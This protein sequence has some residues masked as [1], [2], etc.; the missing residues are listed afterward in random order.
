MK[1]NEKTASIRSPSESRKIFI[2]LIINCS[3]AKGYDHYYELTIKIEAPL[4]E[5]LSL[6]LSLSF[7][8]RVVC[9]CVFGLYE[10]TPSD[11]SK[12][13]KKQCPHAAHTHTKCTSHMFCAV[14]VC[15][16]SRP[17]SNVSLSNSHTIN[18]NEWLCAAPAFN[19][20]SPF[21]LSLCNYNCIRC[22]L[23]P[24]TSNRLL[25]NIRTAKHQHWKIQ[26]YPHTW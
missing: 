2:E 11:I 22:V 1:T 5:R 4:I 14:A 15:N 3:V 24:S 10:T 21:S 23:V 19:C 7:S 9:V 17:P 12:L 25:R 6:F 20:T 16:D 18:T 13:S 26:C 8:E